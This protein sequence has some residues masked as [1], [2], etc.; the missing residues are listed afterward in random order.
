MKERLKEIRAYFDLNM[1]D[2][3]GRLGMSRSSISLLESGQR[4]MTSQ[5]ISAVCREYG[6]SE[7]WLRNGTGDMF[8][9]SGREMEVARI[10]DVM[11][12][13]VEPYLKTKLIRMVADAPGE[14]LELLVQ[15]AREFIAAVDEKETPAD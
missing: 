5:F 9:I 13:D 4:N 15:K 8:T 7:E 2:F 11:L 12:R 3:A 14:D 1:E 10:A 6:V